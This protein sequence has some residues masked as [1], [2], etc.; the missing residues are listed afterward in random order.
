M[1][2]LIFMCYSCVQDLVEK[3]LLPCFHDLNCGLAPSSKYRVYNNTRSL[4]SNTTL[5]KNP[6]PRLQKIVEFLQDNNVSNSTK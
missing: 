5:T 3:S 2:S 4:L 1:L 6:L